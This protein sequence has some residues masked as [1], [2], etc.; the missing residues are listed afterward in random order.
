M[1]GCASVQWRVV[2]SICLLPRLAAGA[3]FR[4]YNKV[5]SFRLRKA[6]K[7]QLTGGDSPMFEMLG[8][9]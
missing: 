9:L 5:G 3:K 2:V 1:P 6:G 7:V 4:D 8:S